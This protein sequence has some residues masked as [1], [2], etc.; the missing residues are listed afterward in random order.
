MWNKLKKAMSTISYKKPRDTQQF[1][2]PEMVNENDKQSG[3][4]Q[5]TNGRLD[6]TP[7]NDEAQ[8]NNPSDVI[9]NNIDSNLDYMKKSFNYTINGDIKI[10]EFKLFGKTRAFIIYIDGMV[11]RNIINRD[12]I[13]PLLRNK[14]A[15]NQQECSAQYIID[16]VIETNAAEK[17]KTFEEVLSGILTGDTGVY[18]DGCDYYIVCETK[19]YEKRNVDKP[20]VEAVISGAQE[21]FNENLR[22]NTA[23]IRRIIKNNNLVAEYIKIGERSNKICAVMYINGLVNPALVEEVKRRIE[24]I[25]TDFILGNG[26]LLQFIESERRSLFPTILSTERPDRAA[27]NIIE[28]KVAILCEGEPFTLIVPVTAI[29]MLH[30]SEDMAV[31]SVYGTFLRIIRLAALFVATFLPGL[32]I[33]ITNYHQEM[34]PTELLIA[35]GSAR[36]SVPIPTILEVILME[37]SFEL[38]REAGV[39]VPGMLGTTIGI[40]GALVLGQAA[41]QASLVSPILII[42]VALTGLGNFA[43]PN[44][45]FSFGVRVVRLLYIVAGAVLGFYGIAVLTVALEALAVDMKSFGVPYLTL[46]T[47]RVR[48]SKD[49]LIRR[50]VWN[51]EFRPDYV[52]PLDIRRQPDISRQWTTEK[53]ENGH[54]R[55]DSNE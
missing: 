16:S 5:T 8:K 34:I 52:N 19:G 48:K 49:V 14:G 9:P 32:Y 13:A 51:Q 29:E 28:G 2:I 39:R 42:I 35:I 23:L 37:A 20:Q 54:E 55:G 43:I 17:I 21:A 38:I 1:Y 46:I 53:S 27:T 10:R 31:R 50:A 24:G 15:N 45:S 26:M 11:D 33:A 6:A 44:I 3:K 47:P 40:I 7:Q 25:K 4:E 30:T 36:E 18:V 12:I 41:V 22:T